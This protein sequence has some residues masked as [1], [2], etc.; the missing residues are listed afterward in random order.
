MTKTADLLIVGLGA[1]GAAALYQSVKTGAR[2]I[3]IDRFGP[4]HDQ[5]SSHGDTRITRQAIGEGR[6]F[7]PLV[8]RS[9]QIWEELESA[10]GRNL[11]TRNGGL[12]LASPARGSNHHGS[13]SFIQDTIDT[14]VEFGIPHEKLTNSDIQSRYPQFRLHGDEVGYFEAG[15]GFLRPEA[16]I[17]VQLTMANHYGAEI[18]DYETFVS[19]ESI[20]GGTIRITTDKGQYSA[21]KAL[22]TVGPWMQ[23]ML[24]PEHAWLF[25]V[26]RQVMNWFAVEQ[27]VERYF[28]DRFPVFIWITGPQPRDMLYG[29]PAVDGRE[30][31]VKISTEQYESPVDPDTVMRTSTD[32][33]AATMHAEYIAPRFP[34]ISSRCLRSQVCLYTVTPDAKFVIDH[35]PGNEN[36]WFASACSGHG[37]KHSAAL[38]EALAQCALGHSPSADLSPFRL[39]RFARGKQRYRGVVPGGSGG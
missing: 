28:A 17:E 8:L 3:G 21:A 33:E 19:A 22:L 39:N 35:V 1:V 12:I 4:P 5:G 20:A 27:G 26:Y 37:F 14:A 6:D 10:T 36:I 31:G 15:A 29:F 34:D 9:N 24:G 18:L 38:G 16:C 13:S 11:V 23:Q 2:V 32:L 25:R 30:A 7:V